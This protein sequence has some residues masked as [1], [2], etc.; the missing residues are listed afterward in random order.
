MASRLP[1]VIESPTPLGDLKMHKSIPK[2][3]NAF[4]YL[5]NVKGSRHFYLNTHFPF[6]PNQGIALSD[7]LCLFGFCDALFPAVKWALTGN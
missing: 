6:I 3:A 5:P 2:T 7:S 4:I 1:S